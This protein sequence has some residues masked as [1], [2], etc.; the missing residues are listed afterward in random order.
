MRLVA[1]AVGGLRQTELP[2]LLFGDRLGDEGGHVDEGMN[3]DRRRPA[4]SMCVL[5]CCVLPGIIS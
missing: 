5:P 3:D 4:S 2:R 1:V